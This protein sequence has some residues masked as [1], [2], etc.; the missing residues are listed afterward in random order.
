MLINNCLLLTNTTIF[1]MYY[2]WKYPAGCCGIFDKPTKSNV[3]NYNR[4]F[5]G[6]G[7]RYENNMDFLPIADVSGLFC[8]SVL[9]RKSALSKYFCFVRNGELMY[10]GEGF[11]LIKSNE[12]I[13][14]GGLLKSIMEIYN[15]Y[16][17]FGE[18]CLFFA[19]IHKKCAI[20]INNISGNV[21]IKMLSIN[22]GQ[23]V[24]WGIVAKIFLHT[25]LYDKTCVF[26]YNLFKTA[27]NFK[28]SA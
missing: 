26:C 12:A 15:K 17:T 11:H 9:V 28:V 27:F 18:R 8:I 23:E 22:E 10:D 16:G 1:L 14:K 5:A 21:E 19:F 24:Y 4:N 3:E 20:L 13:L 25:I 2:P 7:H 6:P